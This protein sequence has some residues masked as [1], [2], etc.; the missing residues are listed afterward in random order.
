MLPKKNLPDSSGISAQRR[1]AVNCHVVCN[2]NSI[3]SFRF[4]A[5]KLP[6]TLLYP[7]SNVHRILGHLVSQTFLLDGL[8]V[9]LRPP[10]REHREP[11]TYKIY[12]VQPRGQRELSTPFSSYQS[13]SFF[14]AKLA[15]DRFSSR[16]IQRV[17][18][19]SLRV[20]HRRIVESHPNF[21]SPSLLLR[22]ESNVCKRIRVGP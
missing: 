8:S 22:L 20:T 15:N 19:A 7:T 17:K 16:K 13:F 10:I 6:P 3:E 18:G 12:F 5:T 2:D 9:D 21:L 11:P 1:S 4:S 14:V